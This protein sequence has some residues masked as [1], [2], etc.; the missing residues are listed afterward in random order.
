MITQ[1]QFTLTGE[2]PLRSA[3]GYRLYS[4]LQQVLPDSFCDY[5]HQNE[6]TPIAQNLYVDQTSNQTTWTVSLL[7]E[8]AEQMACPVLEHLERIELH[9]DAYEVQRLSCVKMD[10]IYDVLAKADALGTENRTTLRFC[11]PTAFKQ[12]GRYVL[13]PQERLILQSLIAKWGELFPQYLLNDPDAEQMLEEG[14]RISDYRLRTARY[15]LK[16]VRIPGFVGQITI[17]AH[18][19]APMRQLWNS[20]CVL[21]P[22]TGVGIK[23]A[24]GMGG[25]QK[26]CQE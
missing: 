23:T 24:L 18:L 16:G 19:S 14:I 3:D 5:L 15:A 10:S 4:W 26:I 20:L 1:F 6:R 9:T 11:S 21:A 25:V 2:N 17:D 12:N 13:F 8:G 7:G 22:F